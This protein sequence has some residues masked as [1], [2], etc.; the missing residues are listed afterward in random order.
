MMTVRFVG[1]EPLKAQLEMLVLACHVFSIPLFLSFF[2]LC[3]SFPML[4]PILFLY[5]IHMNFDK[6]P[7]N[8]A[9][10]AHA[11]R[12]RASKIW[13]YFAS[14]FPIRLHK[15]VNLEPCFVPDPLQLPPPVPP[16]I[17]K[18]TFWWYYYL[19]K[20]KEEPPMRPTGRRYIFGY[21]PHGIIGMG[22]VGGIASEGANWSKLFPGITVRVLTLKKQFVVPFYREYLLSL[23]IASV[24]KQSCLSLLRRNQPI[25][26]VVGGAQESLLAQPGKM[27]LVL[28][29]R[30]GFIKLAMQVG[31]ASLVPVLA[32]GE[33]DIYDQVKNHD[34]TILYRLQTLMKNMVGF[35][36]PLMHARGVLNY[37]VGIIPYRRPIDIVVGRPIHVAHVPHPTPKQIEYYQKLY[38][39]E[40]QRLFDDNKNKYYR[41]WTHRQPVEN[42]AMNIV[43]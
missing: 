2:M 41:D 3:C 27:D 9:P 37:D 21:H 42:F 39:Q 14:Y 12:F 19:L 25:C 33:N 38:I 32:F 4:W 30:H 43:E 16:L 26:I 31:N 11:S 7:V 18:L 5:L 35:T 34:Q 29:K 23:G 22:L 40:L 24:S 36:L 13:K 10:L 15:T 1:L 6:T 20:P 17:W 28:K 8:G